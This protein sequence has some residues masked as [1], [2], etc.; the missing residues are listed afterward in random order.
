M[1]F[2]RKKQPSTSQLQMQPA[3]TATVAQSASAALAQLNHAQQPVPLQASAN[4]A[5]S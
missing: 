3:Q 5:G 2:F 1:S 4:G